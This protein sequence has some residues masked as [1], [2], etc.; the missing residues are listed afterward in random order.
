MDI[1]GTINQVLSGNIFWI[2]E[3]SIPILLGSK[4]NGKYIN[5]LKF[6]KLN[7]NT[8][9]VNLNCII[10]TKIVNIINILY[11]NNSFLKDVVKSKKGGVKENGRTSNRRVNAYS[12]E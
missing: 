1:F 3:S 6:L 8:I 2:V 9:N 10:N 4:I 5:N 7:Q 12:N 11:F